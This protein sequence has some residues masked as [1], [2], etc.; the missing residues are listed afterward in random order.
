LDNLWFGG[1]IGTACIQ[2]D[3]LSYYH[4]ISNIIGVDKMYETG[5]IVDN[6]TE[7]SIEYRYI[8]GGGRRYWKI[9]PPESGNVTDG[10]PTDAQLDAAFDFTAAQA[11]KGFYRILEDTDGTSLKYYIWSDGT[12][13]WYVALTKAL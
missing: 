5:G 3:A 2:L 8:S 10:V 9:E 11:K 1:S 12:Y 7:S 13:W 6:S 4:Q